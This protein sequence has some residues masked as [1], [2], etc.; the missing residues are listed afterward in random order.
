MM[1]SNL[2]QIQERQRVRARIV[3]LATVVCLTTAMFTVTAFAANMDT[4]QGLQPICKIFQTSIALLALVGI[5]SNAA[6]ALVGTEK[7]VKECRNNIVR[8]LFIAGVACLALLLWR[9]VIEQ[10]CG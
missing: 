6:K 3:S 8:I 4:A 5:G 9:C 1:N 2:E 7:E 10:L